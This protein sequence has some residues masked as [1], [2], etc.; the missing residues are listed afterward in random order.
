MYSELA[1]D[2]AGQTVVDFEGADSWRGP[3]TAYR[4][5]VEYEAEK[6]SEELLESLAAQP[7]AE[8]LTRL[9]VGAWFEACEGGSSEKI[10]AKLVELAPK[11]PNL[12]ALF[13]G[14]ITYEECELSWIVQTDVG[15]LLKAYPK[16]EV[17]RIRGGSSLSFSRVQHPSL[18]QLAI[19]TGG[20]SRS[21]L[22]ELFQCEFPALEHLELLLGEENYGFDGSVEDLQPLLTGKLFP[23]LKALG[24]MNSVISNDI[25]AV[26]VNSP[27]ADRL[28]SIDLSMGTLDDE[29]ARSLMGLASKK[30][31]QCLTL[32]HHYVSAKTLE[33]LTKALPF[34]VI[35]DDPK[36][37]EDDW[38]PI[39]HAE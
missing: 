20:L 10:V 34:D 2:F 4:V 12:K 23:Q 17:L 30:N 3:E 18:C 19:E 22:R 11:F 29:G 15:P 28:E 25:A 37:V 27:L 24:L 38:R 8:K 5:R 21:T 26:L 16:L 32:S 7:G 9:V 13:L 35:A 39:L 36:E 14:D 33:A 31:L 1:E 6:S